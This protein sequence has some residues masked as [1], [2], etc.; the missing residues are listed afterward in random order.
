[1]PRSREE[2]RKIWAEIKKNRPSNVDVRAL[3]T[4]VKKL[5]DEIA[6][7]KEMLKVYEV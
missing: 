5:E 7:F 4:R 2:N 1:M 6:A 3:E